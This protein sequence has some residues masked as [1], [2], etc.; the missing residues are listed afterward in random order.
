VQGY[1]PGVMSA[2]VDQE[3]LTPSQIAALVAFIKTLKPPR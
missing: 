1:K 2:I 3:N